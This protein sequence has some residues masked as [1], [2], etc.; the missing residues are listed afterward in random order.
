MD[1][2]IICLLLC[3]LIVSITGI[4]ASSALR[5]K[6]RSR[7]LPKYAKQMLRRLEE[8]KSHLDR[9]LGNLLSSGP[10][11]EALANLAEH[12]TSGRKDHLFEK[13]LTRR[14]SET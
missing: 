3:S 9:R 8:W 5:V 1:I 10:D 11:D 6:F 7:S 4:F 12:G 2:L 14:R 13:V